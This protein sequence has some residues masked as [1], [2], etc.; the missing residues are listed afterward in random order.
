VGANCP[1]TCRAPTV[2]NLATAAVTEL[3][4]GASEIWLG[5]KDL[6]LIYLQ[7]ETDRPIFISADKVALT[8]VGDSVSLFFDYHVYYTILQVVFFDI[9]ALSHSLILPLLVFI[10]IKLFS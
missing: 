1:E 3:D 9:E 7:E 10:K 8:R 4:V 2:A 5:N 6:Q